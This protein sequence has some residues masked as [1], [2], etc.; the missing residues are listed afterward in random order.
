MKVWTHIKAYFAG[1]LMYHRAM[2]YYK[3]PPETP[4]TRLWN[5]RALRDKL[6]RQIDKLEREVEG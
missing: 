6:D 3:A 5:L 2:A 1:Q 4:V